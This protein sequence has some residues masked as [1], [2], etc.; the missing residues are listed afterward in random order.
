[1]NLPYDNQY[2]RQFLETARA[3]SLECEA[4]AL[5]IERYMDGDEVIEAI[6]FAED[7]WDF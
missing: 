6:N 5:F 2:F 1:M 4:L 3:Q 7:E